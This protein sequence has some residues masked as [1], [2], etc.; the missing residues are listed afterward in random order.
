M[1]LRARIPSRA[2]RARGCRSSPSPRQ[3]AP[4]DGGLRSDCRES[5]ASPSSSR[6]REFD[7]RLDQRFGLLDLRKVRGGGNHFEPCAWNERGVGFCVRLT[8]YSIAR[9][10]HNQRGNTDAAETIAQLWIV[11][12][13]LPGIERQSFA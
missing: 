1:A 12:V 2:G 11:H 10:T 7:E 4:V 3:P 5:A 8:Y 9:A 13:G 6:V